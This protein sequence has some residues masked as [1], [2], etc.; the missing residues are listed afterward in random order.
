VV[1]GG[2]M[3]RRREGE[4][5]GGGGNILKEGRHVHRDQKCFY[6]HLIEKWREAS[7]KYIQQDVVRRQ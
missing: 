5:E 4:C 7:G 1:L 6:T 2:G 3:L